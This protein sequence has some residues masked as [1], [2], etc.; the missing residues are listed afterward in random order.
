MPPPTT[1]RNCYAI[2][3]SLRFTGTGLPETNLISSYLGNRC[4]SRHPGF[5]TVPTCTCFLGLLPG[6]WSIEKDIRHEHTTIHR[7]TRPSLSSVM[8]APRSPRSHHRIPLMCG[9]NTS[10]LRRS[11]SGC[12][13]SGWKGVNG[14]SGGWERSVLHLG[15]DLGNSL[16]E[17]FPSC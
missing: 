12:W 5:S 8:K 15:C 1:V 9:S 16:S 10:E 11:K 13:S 3:N 14:A 4:N 6:P 17:N 2:A 7:A